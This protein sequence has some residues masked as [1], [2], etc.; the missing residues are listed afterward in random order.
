[1]SLSASKANS[2]SLFLVN[3]YY[4]VERI[5]NFV[6]QKTKSSKMIATSTGYTL[7][8]Q[9]DVQGYSV[10]NVMIKA[11]SV[12]IQYQIQAEFSSRPGTWATVANIAGTLLNDITVTANTAVIV[13]INGEFDKLRIQAKSATASTA[14]ASLKSLLS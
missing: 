5:N 1:M 12:D 10:H 6:T 14:W 2:S 9:E 13:N 7:V 11:G 8:F 3:G 4:L